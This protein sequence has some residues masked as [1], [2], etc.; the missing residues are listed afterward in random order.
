[1]ATIRP[2]EQPAPQVDQDDVPTTERPIQVTIGK[3]EVRAVQQPIGRAVPHS[4]PPRT[5]LDEYLRG[6]SGAGR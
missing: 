3:V 2:R 6:R 5:T 4:V 1:M